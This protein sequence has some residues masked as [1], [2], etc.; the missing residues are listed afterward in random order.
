MSA[1]NSFWGK[2]SASAASAAPD[3]ALSA[4]ALGSARDS[5]ITYVIPLSRDSA[6]GAS[7]SPAGGAGAGAGASPRFGVASV[8]TLRLSATN[9]SPRPVPSRKAVVAETARLRELEDASVVREAHLLLGALGADLDAEPSSSISSCAG[10]AA[11]IALAASR[12]LPVDTVAAAVREA[13]PCLTRKDVALAVEFDRLV[14]ERA[15]DSL[16]AATLAR[17]TSPRRG[18][19]A[20]SAAA[21]A[22]AGGRGQLVHSVSDL[23]VRAFMDAF[24]VRRIY[25]MPRDVLRALVPKVYADEAATV[26]AV[27][28]GGENEEA[29]ATPTPTTP[30]SPTPALIDVTINAGNALSDSVLFDA[31]YHGGASGAADTTLG[32]AL[33][34]VLMVAHLRGTLA[35]LSPRR[36]G[37]GVG[38]G[39]GSSPSGSPPTPD[40][41]FDA[42]ASSTSLASSKAWRDRDVAGKKSASDRLRAPPLPPALTES[43]SKSIVRL[44][45]DGRATAIIQ[46]AL[47]IRARF[48]EVANA[49]GT[50]CGVSRLALPADVAA[51]LGRV[52]A[53]GD[54]KAVKAATEAV[55]RNAA[56]RSSLTERE[57]EAAILMGQQKGYLKY[58][59]TIPGVRF[60]PTPRRVA[61]PAVTADGDDEIDTAADPKIDYNELLRTMD[62]RAAERGDAVLGASGRIKPLKIEDIKYEA[63]MYVQKIVRQ[64]AE[65]EDRKH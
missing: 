4:S 16:R 46:F 25:G 2:S 14:A 37:K 31:A 13:L 20:S 5:R 8:P 19:E 38:T 41:A 26:A 40:N 11:L 50:D 48:L 54:A 33:A 42:D 60:T 21:T 15:N 61:D 63:K 62:R 1:A 32:D 27:G 9:A 43:V 59:R 56:R 53:A 55:A 65:E 17:A 34:A 6:P 18:G 44:G 12:A 10:A 47:A 49:L 30:I 23:N 29:N 52:T 58:A 57:V 24:V 28:E 64:R 51:M 39:G 45:L 22:S 3:S 36:G 7:R 35:P